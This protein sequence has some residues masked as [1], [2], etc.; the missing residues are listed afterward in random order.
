MHIDNM[1]TN[2]PRKSTRNLAR[3]CET[4]HS[5]YALV[6]LMFFKK[7]LGKICFLANFRRPKQNMGI[8]RI[9]CLNHF[10]FFQQSWQH[11][12]RLMWWGGHCGHWL[13]IRTTM[14]TCV[15]IERVKTCARTNV[16]DQCPQDH[17]HGMIPQSFGRECSR[18]DKLRGPHSPTNTSPEPG[19]AHPPPRLHKTTTTWNVHTKGWARAPC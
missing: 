6:R 16:A 2:L 13:P 12:I 19:I 18:S 14:N 8:K 15:K 5:V 17:L 7:N 3:T 10:T 11:A 4:V 9:N 1:S